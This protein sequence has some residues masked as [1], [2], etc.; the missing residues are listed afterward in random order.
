MRCRVRAGWIVTWV[1]LVLTGSLLAFAA[2]GAGSLP[3]DLVLT[4]GLQ[5]LPPNDAAGLL[6]LYIDNAVWLLSVAALMVTLLWRR[7]L[8]AVFIFLAG[9]TGT[10]V[11]SI[12]K[13]LTVRPRPS[14]EVVQVY[15]SSESYSFPSSTALLSVV[16][17]GMICYL[18]WSS[19]LP[20]PV[21]IV[22]LGI[23][24]LSVL[25]IGLSRVYVGEHWATDVLGGWL[26]G[27]AWLLLLV[28]THYRWLARQAN[29]YKS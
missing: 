6:L 27:G 18:I 9:L 21:L 23:A 4:R 26:F 14:I 13:L 16:L 5:E 2:R 11:G 24:L 1:V 22:A 10:L 19:R 29:S 25:T 17:L 7:W 20:R 15:E 8:A 12:L 3:G 28:A